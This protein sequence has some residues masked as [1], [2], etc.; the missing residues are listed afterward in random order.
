MECVDNEV[1]ELNSV[2]LNSNEYVHVP[3]LGM[4][5]MGI[6]S[7]SIY[8]QRGTI[9]NIRSQGNF[10]I[11]SIYGVYCDTTCVEV[12]HIKLEHVNVPLSDIK[13]RLGSKKTNLLFDELFNIKILNRENEGY[14][15]VEILI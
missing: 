13:C 14:Y 15:I 9:V 10:K 5:V 2:Y 8:Y 11:E 4:A 7:G 12:K 6:F 1:V 3:I